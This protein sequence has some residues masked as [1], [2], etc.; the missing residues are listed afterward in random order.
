MISRTNNLA[1]NVAAN[2]LRMQIMKYRNAR[3]S[4]RG[5]SFGVRLI[6]VFGRPELPGCTFQLASEDTHIPR[7]IKCQCHSI[8]RDP[9]NLQNDVISDVNPFTDFSTK[10]QHAE[11]SLFVTEQR[12]S[13]ATRPPGMPSRVATG[14]TNSN[15]R[16]E[17]SRFDVFV[18]SPC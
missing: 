4:Q 12:V 14:V 3:R 1:L 17:N 15:E 2:R 13:P 8:T 7:C 11:N 9:A 6:R 10:N 16:A 18:A 5:L